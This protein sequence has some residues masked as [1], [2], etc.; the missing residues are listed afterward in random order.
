MNISSYFPQSVHRDIFNAL[1][2]NTPLVISGVS[3][4]TAKS[5]LIG[6]LIKAKKINNIFWITNGNKDIYDIEKNIPFWCDN[7]VIALDNLLTES[8]DDYRITE[9]I[10]KIHE[11]KNKFYLVSNK[12]IHLPMPTYEEIVE[13]GVVVEMGQDMRTVEFFNKLIQ[14]GY[15]PSMDVALHKGEYRRSGGVVNVYPPN[16]DVIIKIEVDYDKITGIWEYN[17]ETKQ[18]GKT[19]NKIDFLPINV[20]GQTGTLLKHITQD[21]LIIIDDIDEQT[22]KFAT[23]IDETP[24]LKLHFTSFP[25]SD[26]TYF[27]LRYLSV[28]KYYNIFDLLNDLRD[29]IQRDWRINILTKRVKEITNI[30]GEENIKYSLKHDPK[31]KIRIID[32]KDL[33]NVPTSFQNPQEN[34]Q[35]LTDKEIF[36]LRRTTKSQA[37]QKINLDFLTGLRMGDLIVHMDHGIGRFLGV[38]PKTIDDIRREYLEIAYAENDRLFIPIDQADKIS[39]YVGGEE[40]EPQLSRLG[41]AEWKTVS[42][43]IKKETQKIAKELLQLYAERAQISGHNYGDDTEDQRRFDAEFPYEETPGQMKAIQDVKTDME[44]DQPMDRLVCGDVGFGKTEVAMR[45]AFKAVQGGKQVA[46]IAPITILADQHLKSFQKR[47]KEFDIRVEMMSRFRS[48]KEQKDILERLRKGDIDVVIGTHRLLQDDVKFLKLGLVIIDEEQRFGVKQKEKFK[49][50]R[51]QVDI[52]TLTATPIPRTLNLALNKFRDIST[53][54]TPPPGRLPIITEV[55]RHG[56]RLI[57][58]AIQRETDRDGQVYFL[59]NRVETIESIAEKLRKLMPSIKFIV[60]HGQLSP[61]DLEDRIMKFKN[62]EFDVLVSSTIIENGIDLPN[63]NTLIVDNAENFGLSQLYQLRGR[64]GRSKIQAYAYFL[65]QSRQLRLDAKKRLKAIVD[66]SELGSGFQVAMR[67]LEIRGAGDILGVNQH[68]TIRVVGVNHFL[69]ML[70]K[71]IE[72]VRAGKTGEGKEQAPD[73]SIELPLEAYIPDNYIPDT[74]DK[75]NA[76]QKLSSVNNFELLEEFKDD[77]MVE[78]GHFPKQVT[79]LFQI[80]QIKILAKMAGLSNIKSIPM[81]DAGRQII[82]HMSISVTAEQI[83]N[84]LKHNP[85]WLISGEKLKIDIKHLGFNWSEKLKE[86]VK[87]L[88]PKSKKPD[89]KK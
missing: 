79:N 23:T 57:V 45:A 16:S 74:K 43:K 71:T 1:K 41:A 5:Y 88:I 6:A 9:T 81:G 38:V 83:M 55:R 19:L 2:P 67:D 54:T 12:D 14:M 50:I 70:N 44:S 7:S 13:S 80:L 75:I 60:A 31:S 58:D 34:I 65:Y 15:Q 35:L 68:G 39:K 73:V 76:Y 84:L 22:E 61:H 46:F 4:T 64:I 66:A 63:A 29:K 24:A 32:A 49:T 87:L 47:T 36:N 59:H 21:D 53:I 52:L 26:E 37:G 78:Y 3:N 30:F 42:Q 18:L 33:E 77:L 56:D 69:R 10:S 51:S 82:L 85:K 20:T 48:P 8:R 17:Q 72:E 11:K 28:L 27:H 40:N 89:T 25:Q 62:K 86:N